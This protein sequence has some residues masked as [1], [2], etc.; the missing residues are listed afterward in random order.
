MPNKKSTVKV[1]NVS[2]R[3][4]NGSTRKRN[5][6]CKVFERERKLRKDKL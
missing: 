1:G 4:R 5:G 2:R 6:D 3:E